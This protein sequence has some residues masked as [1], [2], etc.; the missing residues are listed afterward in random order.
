MQQT[1][2]GFEKKFDYLVWS[3]LFVMGFLF[4]YFLLSHH[5]VTNFTIEILAVTIGVVLV[6]VS[7]GVTIRMQTQYELERELQVKL[8]DTKI[9]LYRSL[10]SQIASADHDDLI[11]QDEIKMIRASA[12]ELSLLANENVLINIS[13][14]LWVLENTKQEDRDIYLDNIDG[15]GV[16]RD[17]FIQNVNVDDAQSTKGLGTIRRLVRVM[18]DDLEVSPKTRLPEE[19]MQR[20]E[21]V[22][23]SLID[24]SNTS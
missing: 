16:L 1:P 14:F 9:E 24:K 8:Y 17:Q 18:R 2:D 5:E 23:G 13:C 19:Q 4:I 3:S 12:R 11:S 15:D 21:D 6:V 20:I 10:L 22:V 7:V